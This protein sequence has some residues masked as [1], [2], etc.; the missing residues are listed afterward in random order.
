MNKCFEI[1][2]G[3]LVPSTESTYTVHISLTPITEPLPRADV[4][5]NIYRKTKLKNK[6]ANVKLTLLS[7]SRKLQPPFSM[8]SC[9][10]F[11]IV[12]IIL[13]Q[14]KLC[15]PSVYLISQELEKLN[16]IKIKVVLGSLKI[17]FPT[18]TAHFTSLCRTYFNHSLTES[19]DVIGMELTCST[20]LVYSLKMNT[21]SKF[22]KWN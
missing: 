15:T 1:A 11:V 5:S 4:Y 18:P 9:G 13:A 14:F 19:S 20:F 21:M 10:S 12:F 2:H 17:C 3:M 7:G 16:I 8:K 22:F 6:K